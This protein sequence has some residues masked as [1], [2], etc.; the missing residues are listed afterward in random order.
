MRFGFVY[1]V[2]KPNVSVLK[3]T[4]QF[5]FDFYHKTILKPNF[6]FSHRPNEDWNNLPNNA[7]ISINF[8]S[9]SVSVMP[10]LILSYVFIRV[11]VTIQSL[12]I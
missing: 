7:I 2:R 11:R 12:P 5:R 6:R 3:L 4:G 8:N 10:Y 9:I 1:L